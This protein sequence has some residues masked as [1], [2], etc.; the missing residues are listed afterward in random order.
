MRGLPM[1]R[2]KTNC[3]PALL[4]RFMDGELSVAEHHRVA[5][6]VESCPDCLKLLDETRRLSSLL[7]IGVQQAAEKVD[8]REMERMISSRVLEY[9]QSGKTAGN[10]SWLPLPTGLIIP[11]RIFLPAAATIAALAVV[12]LTLL[13]RPDSLTRPSAI[14]QSFQGSVTS[15]MILETPRSRET[16][17][18]FSEKDMGEKDGQLEE[19]GTLGFEFPSGSATA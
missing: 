8:S 6:H 19:D 11:K 14:V 9:R 12:V 5:A 17:L 2:E 1:E 18:W 13:G 15:V 10:W 4:N 3:D 7:K 16:I